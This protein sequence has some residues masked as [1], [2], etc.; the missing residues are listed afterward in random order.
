MIS[1]QKISLNSK[2]VQTEG[3]VVSDMDGEKVMLSIESGNYYNLGELGGEIWD[4]IRT[5][6]EINK[7]VDTLLLTYEVEKEICEQHVLSYIEQLSREGL[8]QVINLGE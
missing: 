2:V 8:I 4:L 3:N 5:P 6:I 7:L 1:T